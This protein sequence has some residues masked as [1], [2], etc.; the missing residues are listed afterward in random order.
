MPS[1]KLNLSNIAIVILVSLVLLATGCDR[2]A[3]PQKPQSSKVTIV[4]TALVKARRVEYV[5]EQVGSLHSSEQAT[6]RCQLAGTIQQILFK[7][8]SKVKAGQ[9]L[10]ILDAAKV[11]A[12]IRNLEALA[13]QHQTRLAFQLKTLE[14]NQTLR[15]KA[16]I[17]QHRLDELESQVKETQLA[18]TQAKANLARQ[19]E[20]LAD[21]VIKAPFDGVVGAKNLSIGDYLKAGDTVVTVTV[22]DP[23]EISFQVPELY[24]SKVSLGQ[25]ALLRV[26]SEGE[27][28]FQGNIFFIAPLVDERTRTFQ[29]KARVA[30]PD[31]RLNPGMFCRIRLVTEVHDQAPTVPWASVIQ[32]EDETYLFL[33][34]DGKAK[35][36]PVTLGMVTADWAEIREPALTPGQ[37]VIVEGKFNAQSGQAVKVAQPASGSKS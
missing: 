10:V 13:Q 16:A 5:L 11:R 14:R 34:Q 12:E 17:A 27:K 36:V 4:T 37:Q 20:L 26:A 21:T 32:T 31:G 33:V 23:L 30:N 3:P 1:H 28:F 18:I 7:E 6:L 35:K 15:K 9:V 8:G 19:R 29:V 25:K 22:L 2:Q 24:K